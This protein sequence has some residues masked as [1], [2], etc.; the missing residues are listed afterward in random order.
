MFEMVV[1]VVAAVALTLAPLSS[2]AQ[3]FSAGDFDSAAADYASA[4]KANPKDTSALVGLGAIRLYRNDL[5]DAEPLLNAAV[6][7][8]PDNSRAR[9]LLEELQRRK[10]EMKRPASVAGGRTEVPFVTSDPLPVVRATINGKPGT[11][12]VD[13]GGTLDLHENFARSLGLSLHSAGVGTFAGGKHAPLMASTIDSIS[14]GGATA[15]DVPVSVLPIPAQS[16]FHRQ[17]DGII[18]TTLFERFLVT[19]D[20]PHSRLVIRTR[21]LENSRDFIAAANATHGTI[22]PCWLVGDHFVFARASVNGVAPGLFIFDSGLAG[23]GFSP[24]TELIAAAGIRV[25]RSAAHTGIGGG[26]P[27]TAIPVMAK[28]VAVGDAVQHDVPGIYTPEG[29]PFALFPFKV[30]GAISDRYLRH[31][32]YTVDFDA[33]KIVLTPE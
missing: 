19:I 15:R 14:I 24:A 6:A 5:T 7:A 30:W 13:T 4:L 16:I 22:V 9:M 29:N 26:G 2:A 21:S 27:V 17:I 31:Y 23:G 33:M 3:H 25:D 32:A 18:G 11:F 28:D 8:D 10:V 20:Y 1:A 12:A